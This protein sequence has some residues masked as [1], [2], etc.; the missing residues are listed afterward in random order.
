MSKHLNK[1]DVVPNP[2]R[3]AGAKT[4]W[5]T[6]KNN[7]NVGAI[8]TDKDGTITQAA[9]EYGDVVGKNISDVIGKEIAEKGLATNKEINLTGLDLKIGG[10]GMKGF[11]DNIVPKTIENL[12][13]NTV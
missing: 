8:F 1:L 12:G 9:R 10:E 5:P 11:Y 13:S 7:R 6:D 4:W 2:D 3:G